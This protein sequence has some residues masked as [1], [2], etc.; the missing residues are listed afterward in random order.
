MKNRREWQNIPGN[1]RT[2][3]K[4]WRFTIFDFWGTFI[5]CDGALHD[6]EL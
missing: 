2:I 6:E 1:T 3:K 5:E 4:N